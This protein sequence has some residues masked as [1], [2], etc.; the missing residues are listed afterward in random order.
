MFRVFRFEFWRQGRRRAFLFTTF[1]VPLIALVLLFGYQFIQERN[2]SSGDDTAE[3]A[4]EAADF[5]TIGY[6]DYSGLFPEPGFFAS[7]LVHYDD[8][9]TALAA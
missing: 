4:A 9:E 6:V 5:G 1:G 7:A 3:A 2:A 8:E